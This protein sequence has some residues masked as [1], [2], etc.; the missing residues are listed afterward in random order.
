[1]TVIGVHFERSA[2]AGASVAAAKASVP[3][4]NQPPPAPDAQSGSGHQP[5]VIETADKHP[6]S[7]ATHGST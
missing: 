4:V 5:H 1:M 7:F 2:Q 3:S 6:L